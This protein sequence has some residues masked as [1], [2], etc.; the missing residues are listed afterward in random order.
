MDLPTAVL[1]SG[2]K[3]H[4]TLISKYFLADDF[5]NS[6]MLQKCTRNIFSF[7]EQHGFLKSCKTAKY[8]S[9]LHDG[10]A[11]T[12]AKYLANRQYINREWKKNILQRD[13]LRE[14]K[15][16]AAEKTKSHERST[17]VFIL[18]SQTAD[19]IML[20]ALERATW[21]IQSAYA[22]VRRILRFPFSNG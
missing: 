8:A 18:S 15:T 21:L 1:A 6:F 10:C 9:T 17:S 14:R 13:S 19:W 12:E 16:S 22:R 4:L 3:S 11:I 5:S 7:L 20:R 2:F